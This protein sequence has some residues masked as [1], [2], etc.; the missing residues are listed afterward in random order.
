[1]KRGALVENRFVAVPAVALFVVGI[2][3][4][5]S[6]P[7]PSP[8]PGTLSAGTA[9]VTINDKDMPITHAVACTPSG[10]LTTIATG[11]AAAG[12]TALVSNGVAVT[13]KS[14]IIHD[15]GGFTGSYSEGL[16]GRAEATMSNRTYTIRGVA[17]GFNADNPSAR[18]TD[19]FAV[20]VAC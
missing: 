17:Y 7:A 19:T 1:M 3:G 6:P 5:S 9:Q 16:D 12:V 10:S 14:V 4:C 15:L 20:K 11:D 2:G 18:T 8:P 13:A